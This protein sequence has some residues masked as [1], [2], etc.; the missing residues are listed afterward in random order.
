MEM[1]LQRFLALAGLASRRKAEEL[2]VE[3]KVRVNGRVVD[4]LGSKVDPDRDKVVVSGRR[5]LAERPVYLVLC[6]PRGCVSTLSDP[7]GRPTVMDVVA[8]R[9]GPGADVRLYPVGRLDFHTDG[10][11]LL[12]NDGDLAN[13]LMHPRGG[14]KKTYHA[15]LRGEVSAEEIEQLRA[16][17]VLDDGKKT[18][19]AEVRQLASTGLHTWLEIIIAQGLNR[20][21]HRMA[22]AIGHPLLKLSR[23]AYGPVQV[24]DLKP[25]ELRQLRP[26]ELEEL[27]EQ[28]GAL[29]QKRSGVRKRAPKPRRG[30]KVL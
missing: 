7:E 6:K 19:P 14:V 1:R 20:Q 4:E 26:D 29:G 13:A 30:P 12:T 24:E 17:V 11:L 3:G 8:K 15:K 16:G 9:L 22:D 27:R 23:V 25:G 18:R 28:A 21:I 5:V 2:I 10:V